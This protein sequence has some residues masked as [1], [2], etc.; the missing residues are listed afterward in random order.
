M[1][2]KLKILLSL[3]IVGVLSLMMVQSAAG[4]VTAIVLTA[5]A[6]ANATHV[7][8]LG[9]SATAGRV[10]VAVSCATCNA[11]GG[12][13]DTKTVTV[14]N[15][16]RNKSK[17]IT[18]TE[19]GNATALFSDTTFFAVG[20]V[21]AEN[22]AAN[23][24]IFGGNDGDVFNIV[25]D[26]MVKVLTVDAVK[27]AYSDISPAHGTISGAQAVTFSGTVTDSGGKMDLTTIANSNKLEVEVTPGSGTFVD[28]TALTTWTAATDLKSVNYSLLIFLSEGVHKWRLRSKDKTNNINQIDSLS[29]TTCVP[30]FAGN[31]ATCVEYTLEV[32]V[33][34]PVI[35][36]AKTGV[37]WNAS[38]LTF[39][40]NVRNS[41]EVK[42]VATGTAALDKLDSSSLQASDFLVG[43][44]GVAPTGLT[45]VDLAAG[46]TGNTSGEDLRSRVFLTMPTDFAPDA[47]PEVRVVSAI[48][49]KAGKSS[50]SGSVTSTDGIGPNLVVTI[51][52]TGTTGTIPVTKKLITIRAVADEKSLNNGTVAIQRVENANS[53]IA[54][55]NDVNATGKGAAIATVRDGYEWTWTF[56]FANAADAGLY[57]VL[58]TVTDEAANATKSGVLN[59]VGGAGGAA[60]AANADTTTRTSALAHFFEADLTVPAATISPGIGGSAT[61]N[62]NAFI[63]VSL[64]GE[65]KEYGLAAGGGHT[66][67]VADVVT[68]FDSHN[69]VALTATSFELDD[70][71]VTADTT[72]VTDASGTKIFYKA[73]G[74][75][76]GEHKVDLTVTDDA[77]TELKILALKFE[78]KARSATSIA[79]IPGAP[80][81]ISLPGK[82]DDT[83]I[84]S[85][86]PATVPVTSVFAFDPTA[87]GG[88]LVAARTCTGG[89]CGDFEGNLTEID[90]TKPL[91]ITTSTS[92]PLS[93]MISKYTGGAGVAGALPTPPPSISLIKGWN[94][95]PV[96]DTI[97]AGAAIKA[98]TYVTGIT[99]NVRK[100]YRYDSGNEKFTFIDH[101]N[102]AVDLN[103]G[104]AVWIY[105]DAAAT[106][107]P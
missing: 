27:P 102:A 79:L 5:N 20:L 83:A 86:I 82:P 17:V 60:G 18:L 65:A 59:V 29:T 62:A 7:N 39:A 58:V 101:T 12:A 34:A 40:P 31:V 53:V 24:P 73:S 16:T 61:E 28:Q 14:T 105:M 52:G 21:S 50:A 96:V 72:A 22:L 98:K 55:N 38:T 36:S 13:A 67:T 68:D 3:G 41:V 70:V 8:N 49:D 78:V 107:V 48:T 74:L 56:T 89:T 44:P 85:V 95:V 46:V 45:F 75:T 32:D 37:G 57:N 97:G 87:P 4:A 77:G 10:G 2:T 30:A 51:T 88:W 25:G 23:P 99:L 9:D 84:A 47:K 92:Q 35:S 19:T 100:V 90:G 80:N 69:G 6:T 42:F 54:T 94:L 11:A 103:I 66:V 1:K 71:D 81:L 104:E 63:T 93:V 91:V 64:A 43:S 76:V 26:T 106:L 33:K 15:V